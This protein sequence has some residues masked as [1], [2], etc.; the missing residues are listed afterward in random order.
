MAPEEA[1]HANLTSFPSSTVISL[2]LILNLNESEMYKW[3][4][5]AV[6]SEINGY[7]F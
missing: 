3:N 1:V 2:G 4:V 5:H 6:L 7:R